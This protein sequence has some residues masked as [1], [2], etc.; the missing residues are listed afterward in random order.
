MKKLVFII[1]CM[2]PVGILVA[3]DLTVDEIISKN[4]KAI[5][6]DKLMNIQTIKTTGKAT[7][8]GMELLI[9]EI[10]KSP[11]KD[12]QEVEVQGMKMIIAIEGETGWIINPQTGSSDPQDLSPEQMQSLIKEGLSDPIV[13]WDNPFLKW[14]ENGIKIDLI[15]KEDMNG[16]PVYN[17][18]FTFKDGYVVNYYIDAEKFIVLK[19]KSTETEQGQT[20]ER[21]IRY[22]DYTDFDGIL[23]PVKIEVLVNGQVGTVG[24]MDKC[25]F[26]IP[27]NDSVFK[28]PAKN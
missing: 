14:K 6:Q 27:V 16:T 10:Q 9:T 5:G 11:D 22:S 25:E 17:L 1:L 12:R 2:L 23:N 24:I 21:E 13:N 3:Q 28:K 18:K 4:L 19:S 7:Q 8:G 26:N 15:G 20:Y